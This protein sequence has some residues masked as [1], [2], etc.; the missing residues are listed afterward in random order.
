MPSEVPGPDARHPHPSKINELPLLE[1]LHVAFR[2]GHDELNEVWID[3][4][5]TMGTVS[6]KT[7]IRRDGA[8]KQASEM[9]VLRRR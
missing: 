2:G 8:I 9:T 5:E 3:Y 6:R 1:G 4:E 7:T